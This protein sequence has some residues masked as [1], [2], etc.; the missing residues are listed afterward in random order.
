MSQN[1]EGVLAGLLERILI[2]AN[3]DADLRTH[4]RGLAQMVLTAT[5][6]KAASQMNRPRPSSRE[7][8]SLK[9]CRPRSNASKR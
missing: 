3:Q 1:L 9:K 8:V 4:L 2:L 7:E 6:Q 5:D